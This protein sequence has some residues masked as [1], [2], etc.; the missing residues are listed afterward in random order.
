M[1]ARPLSS[2]RPGRPSINGATG[3]ILTLLGLAL[4]DPSAIAQK[5]TVGL[6]PVLEDYISVSVRP[7]PAERRILLAG[8]PFTKLLDG[9]PSREVV[10]FGAI[11]I[12]A[13]MQRYTE[14]IRDIENFERGKGFRITRRI[15]SPPRIEDF[16]AMHLSR[17]DVED[18]SKC[19]VGDCEIKLSEPA[20]RRFQKEVDWAASDRHA[21]ADRV[22]RQFALEYVSEYLEGGDDRLAVYRDSSRP[23]FVA[24]E[25]RL[26][27]DQMPRLAARMPNL[28]RYLLDYPKFQLPGA[29]SFLY[30]Q[31]VQFGLKPTLRISHLTIQQTPNETIV[32]SKMLYASHY[33]WTALELRALLPD[34]AR[35]AGFWLITLNRSRSDGLSGFLGRLIR[36]RIRG[37]ARNGSLAALIATK[38]RLELDAR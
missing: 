20:L 3:L 32:A 37:E 35:G 24:R 13:P 36:N 11:W 38:T 30:W 34:P 15:S 22:M 18:L 12:D 14:A 27:I 2:G 17:E 26:M 10:I 25:F 5:T 7:T 28:R 16:S 33:F 4:A 19:R 31:E 6:P 1:S 29:E 8:K 9:D 21:V 23:T